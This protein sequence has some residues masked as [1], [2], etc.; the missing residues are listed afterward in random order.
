MN[1]TEVQRQHVS[2]WIAQGAKLAEIQSRLAEEFGIKLTYMDTRFLVD[3]LKLVPK[4][5]ER[6]KAPEPAPATPKEPAALKATP[7]PEEEDLGGAPSPAP[8]SGGKVSVTV[9]QITRPG[10][11][12]SGKVTF[13]DG[14]AADWY[15]DQ[16]GR[17]GV[18]PKQQGY[19]PSA[20]DVQDFQ[21]AL[22]Q[23]MAK[24]GY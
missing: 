5:P 12:V 15:L 13:T 16:M 4:D 2:T 1:L 10:A 21:L 22:Q 24:M 18:V 23:E 11:I 9:D 17:L 19:K 14:Q 3:D 6:P 7:I 20:A 8:G